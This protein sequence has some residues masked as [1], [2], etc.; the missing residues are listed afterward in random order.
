MSKSI[1]VFAYTEER[2]VGL[3]KF[4]R[5]LIFGKT[6]NGT[7]GTKASRASRLL[8]SRIP[9]N[10]GIYSRYSGRS[11]WIEF[12][13]VGARWRMIQY[14][15]VI[16]WQTVETRYFFSLEA[17][18]N[19]VSALRN[20]EKECEWKR[21]REGMKEQ[22]RTREREREF[23]LLE[24]VENDEKWKKRSKLISWRLL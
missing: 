13:H 15:F 21:E 7:V 4:P 5:K 19:N 17:T 2:R 12:S 16:S 6:L 1:C 9:L 11:P 14:A 23:N 10:V 8:Q 20:R 18:T 3:K 24:A 22:E